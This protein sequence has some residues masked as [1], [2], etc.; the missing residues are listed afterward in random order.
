MTS[1]SHQRLGAPISLCAPGQCVLCNLIKPNRIHLIIY[2]FIFLFIPLQ[3]KRLIQSAHSHLQDSETS[4]RRSCNCSDAD[5]DGVGVDGGPGT[6]RNE[7]SAA[8]LQAGRPALEETGSSCGVNG[9]LPWLMRKQWLCPQERLRV[10]GWRCGLQ[11]TGRDKRAEWR[12]P[13]PVCGV[14]SGATESNVRI[15][16]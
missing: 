3:A 14:P 2:L 12:L 9:W 7:H 6:G 13:S 15:C 10:G 5:S 4:S 11:T 1:P 16:T 8:H